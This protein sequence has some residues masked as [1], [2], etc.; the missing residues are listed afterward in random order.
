MGHPTH[1]VPGGKDTGTNRS[2]RPQFLN[3]TGTTARHAPTGNAGRFGG[4]GPGATTKIASR[5]VPSGV[6]IVGTPARGGGRLLTPRGNPAGHALTYTGPDASSGGGST[7]NPRFANTHEAGGRG[8]VMSGG[9]VHRGT[10][11][12]GMPQKKRNPFDPHSAR[13]G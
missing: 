13:M 4:S 9:K 7:G 6:K 12:A 11:Q 5:G 10:A 1:G 8:G 3:P 2:G